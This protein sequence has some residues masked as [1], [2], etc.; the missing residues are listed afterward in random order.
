MSALLTFINFNMSIFV[1]SYFD[2][3]EKPSISF[4]FRSFACHLLAD[5]RD[6]IFYI[7]RVCSSI[8]DG[9]QHYQIQ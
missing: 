7:F 6:S 1:K 4:N 3:N 8:N 2:N 5:L 9:T